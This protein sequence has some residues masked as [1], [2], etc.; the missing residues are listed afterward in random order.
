M[1]EA[2]REGRFLPTWRRLVQVPRETPNSK[3][4]HA[5]RLVV[6]ESLFPIPSLFCVF[7]PPPSFRH[8]EPD[9]NP[10]NCNGLFAALAF[11]RP[12]S[13]I[14][15]RAPGRVIL[16]CLH[17]RTPSLPPASPTLR[18]ESL[19]HHRHHGSGIQGPSV[20]F[21]EALKAPWS[22]D[23]LVCPSFQ[24]N[25]TVKTNHPPPPPPPVPAYSPVEGH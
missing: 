12:V 14:L 3:G 18:T 16:R 13:L 4:G 5:V 2:S 9:L 6:S 22:L 25:K 7:S 17:Y 11:S 19:R 24:P 23:F 20:V 21:T 8:P 10:K 15:H 1:A